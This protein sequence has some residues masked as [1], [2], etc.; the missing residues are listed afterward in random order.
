MA[1]KKNE[2]RHL[3]ST[4]QRESICLIIKEL[5]CTDKK[6]DCKNIDEELW[7]LDNCK[8][9]IIVTYTKQGTPVKVKQVYGSDIMFKCSQEEINKVY[10]NQKQ[11]LLFV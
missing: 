6:C 2:W 7:Y 10:M 4:D 1:I 11:K 9:Y 3:Y 5:P 8:T